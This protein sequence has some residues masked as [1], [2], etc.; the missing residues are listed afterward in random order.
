MATYKNV[1]SFEVFEKI[2]AGY[3]VWVTDRQNK[4]VALLNDMDAQSAV[5]IVNADNSERRYEFWISEG[6]EESENE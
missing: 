3:D 2:N 6:A 4:S 1:Y 5:K